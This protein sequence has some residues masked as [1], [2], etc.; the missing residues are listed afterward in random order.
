MMIRNTAQASGA[1]MVIAWIR[2]AGA[3]ARMS[4]PAARLRYSLSSIGSVHNDPLN[5]PFNGV[6]SNTPGSA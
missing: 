2:L 4:H 5:S 3:A 6:V 1:M